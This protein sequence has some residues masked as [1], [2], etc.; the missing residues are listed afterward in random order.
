MFTR[1]TNTKKDSARKTDQKHYF[2]VFS[3][4]SGAHLSGHPEVRAHY[5]TDRGRST[6]AGEGIADSGWRAGGTYPP[7]VRS[8]RA[9]HMPAR[10]WEV[11][12]PRTQHA[13]WRRVIGRVVASCMEWIRA[14]RVGAPLAARRIRARFR[15]RVG[16]LMRGSRIWALRMGDTWI[17]AR[18]RA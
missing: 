12:T 1:K 4:D 16:W 11:A 3:V 17:Q 10:D 15:M 14:P 5:C 13:K 8:P 18:F 6:R 7:W 2:C 9:R